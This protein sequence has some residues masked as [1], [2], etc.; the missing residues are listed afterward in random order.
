MCK[1]SL[2][3]SD[4]KKAPLCDLQSGQT[5][6]KGLQLREKNYNSDET[7]KDIPLTRHLSPLCTCMVGGKLKIFFH[8]LRAWLSESIKRWKHI[9][10]GHLACIFT[11][12]AAIEHVCDDPE[13]HLRQQRSPLQNAYGMVR[14]RGFHKSFW[15]L[16]GS[17]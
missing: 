4:H 5:I 16:L 8:I 10:L 9:P 11:I 12:F 7:V 2:L 13:L 3:S 17:Q 14:N 6:L 1:T 15:I